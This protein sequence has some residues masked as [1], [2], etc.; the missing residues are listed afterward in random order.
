VLDVRTCPEVTDAGLL[1]LVEVCGA[2]LNT[3][4]LKGTGERG[5]VGDAT[6][7]ALGTHC[8]NLSLLDASGLDITDAG[9]HALGRGCRQLSTAL[10][11]GCKRLGD[12]AVGMLARRCGPRLRL[13]DLQGCSLVGDEAALELAAHC[14]SLHTV[15][16]QCCPELSDKGFE[17]MCA[18][19]ALAH[20]TLKHC[21]VSEA[22]V[23]AAQKSRPLLVVRVI[24]SG[25]L[26]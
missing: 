12:E 16:F 8:P 24:P 3:L 9:L 17:A 22:T 23:L 7:A 10:L 2:R 19:C 6:L 20:V 18:G 15:S 26:H 5:D 25:R 1:P 11:A 21:Q 4:R 14:P 13:L